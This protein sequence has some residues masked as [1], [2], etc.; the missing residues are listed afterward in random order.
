MCSVGERQP[1]IHIE[2]LFILGDQ[3][4]DS[5][6]HAA[7]I[8]LPVVSTHLSGNRL[9]SSVWNNQNIVDVAAQMFYP[10]DTF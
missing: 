8:K 9:Q 1:N 3:Q 5:S 6:T 4:T 2:P 10:H 7:S